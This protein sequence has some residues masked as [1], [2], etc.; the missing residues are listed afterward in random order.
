MFVYE[1]SEILNF[2]ESVTGE[3]INILVFPPTHVEMYEEQVSTL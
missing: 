2:D 1:L 3:L